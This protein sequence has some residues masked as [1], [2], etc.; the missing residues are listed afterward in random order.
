M[1]GVRGRWHNWSK[2]RVYC[3]KVIEFEIKGVR[4]TLFKL[5]HFFIKIIYERNVAVHPLE[6]I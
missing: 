4:Q 6:V 3:R 1:R 5:Y 2:N